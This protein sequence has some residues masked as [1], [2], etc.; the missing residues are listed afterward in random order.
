MCIAAN[1]LLC[2]FAATHIA[3]MHIRCYAHSLLHTSQ[4]R[5]SLLCTFA[6]TH[7]RCYTLRSYALRSYAH[8]QL[9][10]F[11]ATHFAAMHFA[12]TLWPQISHL[13][14]RPTRTSNVLKDLS[15]PDKFLINI[16][17]YSL[18]VN[19]CVTLSLTDNPS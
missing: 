11:A 8:S 10:T 19:Y 2:T 17:R 1:S 9:R 5:T 13:Y 6:A 14:C 4:L 18:Y 15:T 7:I 12:A 16:F 3:A